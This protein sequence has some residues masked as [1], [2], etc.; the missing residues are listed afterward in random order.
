MNSLCG[1]NCR[2]NR[3]V[4]VYKKEVIH[5]EWKK[6]FEAGER[7]EYEFRSDG[8]WH[9]VDF[10]FDDAWSNTDFQFRSKPC[11][12]NVFHFFRIRTAPCAKLCQ[13]GD[14]S[15]KPTPPLHAEWKKRHEAGEKLHYSFC[16]GEWRNLTRVLHEEAW[17]DPAYQFKTKPATIT[18]N[19]KEYPKADGAGILRAIF[20]ALE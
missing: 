11:A 20:E 17:S 6:R 7:L 9:D 3:P 5:L 8:K 19:G 14:S 4:P 2:C 15:Q 12:M 16:N 18:I 13:Q 10:K 1:C